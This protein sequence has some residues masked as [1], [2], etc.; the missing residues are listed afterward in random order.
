MR[1]TLLFIVACDF[2]C[3]S[4]DRCIKGEERCDGYWT[5]SDGSDEKNCGKMYFF[6]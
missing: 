1:I 6:V 5:C 2:K 4:E 3:E